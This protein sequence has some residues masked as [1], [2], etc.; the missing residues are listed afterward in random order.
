MALG[1]LY[2]SSKSQ[3]EWLPPEERGIDFATITMVLISSLCFVTL[4][5]VVVGFF[6]L[7]L[8]TI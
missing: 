1:I 5:T 6:K 7:L 4:G 2:S 3:T 8:K